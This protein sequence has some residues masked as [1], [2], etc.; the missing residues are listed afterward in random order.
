MH[1]LKIGISFPIRYLARLQHILSTIANVIGGSEHVYV[2]CLLKEEDEEKAIRAWLQISGFCAATSIPEGNILFCQKHSEK[3]LHCQELGITHFVDAHLEGLS[4]LPTVPHRF[5][6]LPDS[7]EVE[8]F[9]SALPDVVRVDSWVK[10]VEEL[11]LTLKKCSCPCN[12]GCSEPHELITED[13]RCL[14]CV[15]G[16]HEVVPENIMPIAMQ[17]ARHQEVIDFLRKIVQPAEKV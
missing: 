10:L 4:L 3:S 11:T 13:G 9:K 2:V 17:I 5:L 1:P 8:R 14:S 16:T 7:D 12:D 6:L 15:S